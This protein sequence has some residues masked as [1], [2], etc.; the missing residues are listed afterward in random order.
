[1]INL[2][3]YAGGTDEFED[4]NVNK[5]NIRKGIS[6]CNKDFTVYKCHCSSSFM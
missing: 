3:V 5:W 2:P 4:T 6:N 1:M